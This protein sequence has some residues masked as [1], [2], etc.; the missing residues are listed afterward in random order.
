MD[1]AVA[2]GGDKLVDFFRVRVDKDLIGRLYGVGT[3]KVLDVLRLCSDYGRQRTAFWFVEH[4]LVNFLCRVLDIVKLEKTLNA[5]G[6]N[7]QP[8]VWNKRLPKNFQQAK[9]PREKL[10]KYLREIPMDPTFQSVELTNLT[11]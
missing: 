8:V 4:L 11:S 1:A 7:V 5:G 2:A 9:E 3:C 10:L 6:G